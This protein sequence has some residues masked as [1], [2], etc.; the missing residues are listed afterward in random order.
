M[1]LEIFLIEAGVR[2]WGP[3]AGDQDPGVRGLGLGVE[4]TRSLIPDH[5]PPPSGSW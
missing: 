4:I 3:G 5:C 1:K 2:G